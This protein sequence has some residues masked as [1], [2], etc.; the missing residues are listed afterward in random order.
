MQRPGVAQRR[1][2]V[3]QHARVGGVHEPVTGADRPPTELLIP[4]RGELRHE[5]AEVGEHLRSHEQVGG[6][7]EVLDPDV[8]ILIEVGR[9]VV[10]LPHRRVRARHLHD[11]SSDEVR[12]GVD[13]GDAFGEPPRIGK[14]VGV[15]ER[16]DLSSSGGDAGVPG[17]VRAAGRLR[18]EPRADPMGAHQVRRRVA[19]AVVDHDHLERRRAFLRRERI[20]TRGNPPGLVQHRHDHADAR[21]CR[22]PIKVS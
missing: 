22:H 19:R 14:T 18:L 4:R 5:P 6:R 12:A 20:E 8:Q 9:A 17:R 11:P 2:R 16:E 3:V 7:G 1:P 15:G 21:R 13:G 10:A